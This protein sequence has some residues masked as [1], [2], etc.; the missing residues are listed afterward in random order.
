MMISDHLYIFM[1]KKGLPA[2][3]AMLIL[4]LSV[5]LLSFKV[6]AENLQSDTFEI[7]DAT[8]NN[9]GQG[10]ASS[11]FSLLSSIG[12][13]AN[14]SRLVSGNYAIQSGFPNGIMA[15]IPL[16]S[17]FETTT[18]NTNSTCANLPN[19]WGAMG[20][21]GYGGCYD[22][23]KIELD[24]QQNPFD[25]LYL[26]KIVDTDNNITY[27]LQS[28][29]TLG[30]SY[31]SSSFMSKCA[32][33]GRDADNPDC[34]QPGDPDWNLDLQSYD[35]LG[36]N[37]NTHYE[38][39]VAA[40]N[41]DYSGTG[42]SPAASA[43]TGTPSL[44]F[45]LNIGAESDP[46]ANNSA[47][48]N[49]SLGNITYTFPVTAD[50]LIWINLGINTPGGL[51]IFVHDLNNGLHS[52]VTD[53]TIPSET[54]DLT[55]DP[56]NNGG[57]G[58]K[59]FNFIPSQLFLGP[60]KRDSAYDTSSTNSVGAVSTTNSLLFSTDSTGGTKGQLLEGKGAVYLKARSTA[61]S[62][63]TSDYHD[64]LTFIIVGNF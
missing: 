33:E 3:N 13:P 44:N 45:K 25:T 11:N 26:I 28:D 14:D 62:P 47:P 9:S 55:A 31:D 10:T 43:Q 35:V 7:Q 50:N 41:G 56:G 17:C 5:S 34:A 52:T 53:Y 42:Y 29:H 60:L 59:T 19:N 15:N 16:I 30:L 20:E 18:D 40:L 21:C 39:Y 37:S 2:L 38:A 24:N 57:F 61:V 46:G 49:I 54:E 12:N 64:I 8:L 6:Q 36:L 22:R 63:A 1:R 32:L 51:N 4:M 23:A 58:L 48:Y 27:F